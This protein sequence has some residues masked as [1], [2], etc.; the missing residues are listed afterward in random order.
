MLCVFRR[1]ETAKRKRRKQPSPLMKSCKQFMSVG[2]EVSNERTRT[3]D[4][5]RSQLTFDGRREAGGA[6]TLHI[7]VVLALKICFD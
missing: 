4:G 5:Y 3:R 1:I 2:R 6:A 7:L